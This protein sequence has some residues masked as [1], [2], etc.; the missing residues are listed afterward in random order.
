M[1][2]ELTGGD[3]FCSSRSLIKGSRYLIARLMSLDMLAKRLETILRNDQA[4]HDLDF[5]LCLQS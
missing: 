1:S 4:R 2:W 3:P 5:V